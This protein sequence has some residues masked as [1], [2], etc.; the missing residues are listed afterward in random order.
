MMYNLGY[1]SDGQPP[2]FG[3]AELEKDLMDQ[4]NEAPIRISEDTVSVGIR[5][6]TEES[7]ENQPKFVFISD[8]DINKMIN[9]ILKKELKKLKLTITGR[10]KDLQER[11]NKAMVDKIC[12][13]PSQQTFR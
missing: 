4:Y 2:Y 3:D 12:V 5:R 6:S 10:K 11:L 1:D 7:T 9:D 13:F 8:A